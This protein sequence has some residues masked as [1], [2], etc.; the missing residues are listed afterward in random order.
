MYFQHVK[1][2]HPEA[3]PHVREL[4]RALCEKSLEL[5]ILPAKVVE[6]LQ[7]SSDTS[8]DEYA[9]RGADFGEFPPKFI[10]P[11]FDFFEKMVCNVVFGVQN[12][13]ILDAQM[14]MRCSATIQTS[15]QAWRVSLRHGFS[16]FLA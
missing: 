1:I 15:W 7:P 2:G 6:N 5:G 9:D 12:S 10:S 13:T 4:R 14:K 8:E 16:Q 11:N 3:C